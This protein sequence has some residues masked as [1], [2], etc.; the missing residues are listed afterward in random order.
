VSPLRQPQLLAE[1]LLPAPAATTGLRRI[2]QM[3]LSRIPRH[4]ESQGSLA[5][6]LTDPE[7]DALY[8]QAVA[9]IENQDLET[10]IRCFEQLARRHADS[11]ELNILAAQANIRWMQLNGW[12]IGYS[13]RARRFIQRARLLGPSDNRVAELKDVF[14]QI[15]EQKPEE[16]D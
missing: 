8:N 7:S 15:E 11:L 10:P 13:A 6:I 1:G 5:R 9:A 4:S 16:D 12:D 14:E 3:I 2:A